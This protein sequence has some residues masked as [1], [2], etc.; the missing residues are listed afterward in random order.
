M[1]SD[2]RSPNVFDNKYYLDLMNTQ[3]LFTSDQDLH[4]DR[5][6][7]QIVVDFAVNQNLFFAKFA[8]SMVNMSMLGVLTGRQGQIRADCSVRNRAFESLSNLVDGEG[9][10]VAF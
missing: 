8:Y 10:A 7:K 2:I 4:S 3:G 1:L 9:E 5:R 6:T